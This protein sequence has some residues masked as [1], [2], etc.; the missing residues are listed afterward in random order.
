MEV[1]TMPLNDMFGGRKIDFCKIDVQGF[2]AN[3]LPGQEEFYK[4]VDKLVIETHARYSPENATYPPCLRALKNQPLD[5]KF[6]IVD[7]VIHCRGGYRK[8]N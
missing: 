2:E 3:I 4:N 5:V 7:G 1:D 6:C 8:K